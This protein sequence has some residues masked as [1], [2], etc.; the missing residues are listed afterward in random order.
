MPFL[1]P[2]LTRRRRLAR[3]P[4][5]PGDRGL[6][7]FCRS[8]QGLRP[9]YGRPW[10]TGRSKPGA[11]PACRISVRRALALLPLRRTARARCSLKGLPTLLPSWPLLRWSTCF[12]RASRRIGPA[13]RL[14]LERATT[15]MVPGRVGPAEP[16]LSEWKPS[17]LLAVLAPVTAEWFQWTASPV[18]PRGG[19]SA[20]PTQ[21][22]GRASFH[23]T[24]LAPS[25]HGCGA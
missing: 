17:P 20:V 15:A 14:R 5:H 6:P 16:A 22:E 11:Q 8:R 12:P 25:S 3:A 10:A 7:G 24:E 21:V 19:I 18:V 13:R 1:R 9:R 2:R 4:G 23:P